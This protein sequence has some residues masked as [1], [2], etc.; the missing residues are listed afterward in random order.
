MFYLMILQEDKRANRK[1]KHVVSNGT[2]ME[3]PETGRNKQ[4]FYFE[5]LID[6]NI[7]YHCYNFWKITSKTSK[8]HAIKYNIENFCLEYLM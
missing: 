8:L 2:K 6:K 1:R 3:L 5:I 7:Q 4:R